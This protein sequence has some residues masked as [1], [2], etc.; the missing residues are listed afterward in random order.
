MNA[1]PGK[2]IFKDLKKLYVSKFVQLQIGFET[3]EEKSS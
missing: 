2:I 3:A 1:N